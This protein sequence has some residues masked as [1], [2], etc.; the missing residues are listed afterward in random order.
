MQFT[1]DIIDDSHIS[2]G[3]RDISHYEFSFYS[4]F[5]HHRYIAEETGMEMTFQRMK[6]E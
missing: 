3:L 1:T 5:C 4:K 2:E 6:E